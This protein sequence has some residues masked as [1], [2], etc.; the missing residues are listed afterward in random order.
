VPALVGE[1]PTTGLAVSPAPAD[2]RQNHSMLGLDELAAGDDDM[3]GHLDE[4]AADVGWEGSDANLASFPSN[5]NMHAMVGGGGG[6]VGGVSGGG[7]GAF[8]PSGM[9]GVGGAHGTK[10]P[11][12]ES[13]LGLVMD[14]PGG[15]GQ[16]MGNSGGGNAEQGPPKA[17]Q[18]QCSI[19]MDSYPSK[20]AA[21]PW[22]AITRERCPKCQKMQIPR[23]DI[24]EPANQIEYHPALVR[25][26]ESDKGGFA[27]GDGDDGMGGHGDVDG[28]LDMGGMGG[29][30]GFGGGGGG[31]GGDGDD[32]DSLEDGDPTMRLPT[33][34]AA[35]L[36]VLI[37]HARTCPGHH[38]SRA[39]SEVSKE[40]SKRWFGSG[41]SFLALLAFVRSFVS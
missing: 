7:A 31:G 41:F 16:M 5:P 35:K 22:W 27:G 24:A 29:G 13:D 21:N 4:L 15:V 19:C 2:I 28:D 17:V 39:H 20:S 26:A 11:R 32:F 10:R 6:G 25:T 14:A 38:S 9:V 40:A 1:S 3:L 34:Q 37:T 18:Y 12:S 30:G 23:I 33:S 8:G 36:L